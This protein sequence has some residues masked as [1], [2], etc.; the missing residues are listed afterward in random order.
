MLISGLLTNIWDVYGSP[1]NFPVLILDHTCQELSLMLAKFKF[2]TACE[3]LLMALSCGI[4]GQWKGSCI[5]IRNNPGDVGYGPITS[6]FA[7]SRPVSGITQQ[8]NAH[9]TSGW[10]YWKTGKNF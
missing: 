6:V 2:I 1:F 3:Q 5:G 7:H 10:S 4:Y 9:I 8:T